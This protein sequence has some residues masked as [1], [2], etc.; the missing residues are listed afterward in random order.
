MEKQ[1]RV[2]IFCGKG[3]VGKTTASLALGLQQAQSGRRAVV[4]SSHPLPELAVGVSLKGLSERFP[5]AAKRFFVVHLDP[6][7]LLAE[8]V[9][10]NFPS[11]WMARGVLNSKIYQNLIEVAPGLKEFYFLSRLQALAERRAPSADQDSPDYD[12][13][14]WDAPATGHFLGTLRSARSFNIYLSGPLAAAGAE[15]ERFFSNAANISVAAVSTL[16]EMAIEETIEMT[17]ALQQDLGLKPEALV[18]NMV[19]PV[20]AAGPGAVEEVR[21]LGSDSSDPALRFAVERAMLE[22][23]HALR[24]REAVAAREIYVERVRQWSSDLD[25]LVQVGEALQAVAARA[26]R[27]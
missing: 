20:T 24:L 27:T 22:R 18:M 17:R 14:I 7:Q 25:L 2:I 16:E 26:V 11:E 9:Q 10:K 5:E 21:E 8:V 15:V 6:K 4:V 3:G 13:L 12:V 1:S 23:E 19:S